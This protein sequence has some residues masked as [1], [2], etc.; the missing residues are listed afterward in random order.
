[1]SN[2]I[3]K[4]GFT[5]LHVTNRS[6]QFIYPDGVSEEVHYERGDRTPDE[7]AQF[8][9][10]IVASCTRLLDAGGLEYTEV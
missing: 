7:W 8:V 4:V 10:E 5:G 9:G 3:L 6:V 1:M 2:N